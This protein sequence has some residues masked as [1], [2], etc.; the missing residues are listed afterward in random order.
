MTPPS[1]NVS[2]SPPLIVSLDSYLNREHQLDKI[3]DHSCA[4]T[5]H[6]AA[7]WWGPGRG[8]SGLETESRL[9]SLGGNE[10]RSKTKK[11]QTQERPYHFT[12]ILPKKNPQGIRSHT[13]NKE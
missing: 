4:H 6:F 9:S 8:H 5:V 10:L 1:T 2:L 3:P 13:E 7:T 12:Y 11:R